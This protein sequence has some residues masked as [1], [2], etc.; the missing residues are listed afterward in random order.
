MLAAMAAGLLLSLP[1]CKKKCHDPQN[2]ECEDYDPCYG[3]K[4]INPVF[5][6]RPGDNGFPPPEDWCDL[7]PCDT[8]NASSVRFDIPLNNPANS[9]Y[10]WQIGSEPT[11]RTRKSF[12]VDFSD[13]L[14][15]GNWEKHIPV[16]LTIRTPLNACMVHPEDTMI[17]VTRQLFFTQ[18]RFHPFGDTARTKI[19]TGFLEDKPD[20]IFSIRLTGD[21]EEYYK[22]LRTFGQRKFLIGFPFADTI[23][24][25]WDIFVLNGCGNY[26][27]WRELTVSYQNP[28][29]FELFNEYSHGLMR[30]DYYYL[31]DKNYLFRLEF[32]QQGKLRVYYFRCR[33]IQ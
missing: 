15:A 26:K 27:H 24:M 11:P 30:Q 19:F 6:V 8:F 13:Y 32:Q 16:T 29:L 3:K 21:N 18:S 14:N 5:R 31:G 25:P 4:R 23:L 2:P 1:A 22:K 10:T 20:E 7:L 17:S 28:Q 12:E 9:A 33:N